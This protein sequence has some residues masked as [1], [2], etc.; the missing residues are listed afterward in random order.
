MYHINKLC[1]L[2][3]YSVIC[4]LYF[5][6]KYESG[7]G[8]RRLSGKPHFSCKQSGPGR[9]HCGTAFDPL[10]RPGRKMWFGHRNKCKGP[11]GG[12]WTAWLQ[13]AGRPEWLEWSRRESEMGPET[14]QEAG[15]TG[16][17]TL[18][19]REPTSDQKVLNRSM[20]SS[21]LRYLD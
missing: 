21:D 10:K 3:V 13:M 7:K 20:T 9:A 15:H 14:W 16:T 18:N 8:N 19:L 1:T 2:N 4:K 17:L 12:E 6:K 5:N 11:E